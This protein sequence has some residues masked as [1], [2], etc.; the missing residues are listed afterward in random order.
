MPE[1]VLYTHKNTWQLNALQWTKSSH[2]PADK[3]KHL[4]RVKLSMQQKLS[5]KQTQHQKEIPLNNKINVVSFDKISSSVVNF[6]P[7]Q[8]GHESLCHKQLKAVVKHGNLSRKKE[9]MSSCW[10]TV[11]VTASASD[12]STTGLCHKGVWENNSYLMSYKLNWLKKMTCR[13]SKPNIR[14]CSS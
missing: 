2:Q 8:P 1:D 3:K 10:N 13:Y 6:I 7:V 9:S 5:P 4:S 11:Y 12:P 14:V